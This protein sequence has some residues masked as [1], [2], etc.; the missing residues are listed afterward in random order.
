MK[1][2]MLVYPLGSIQNN[3]KCTQVSFART[4][5]IG[6]L[7][8]GDIVITHKQFQLHLDPSLQLSLRLKSLAKLG[9][10]KLELFISLGF[11]ITL[12]QTF[13]RILCLCA[14]PQR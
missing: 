14:I 7:Q 5:S 2:R 1:D 11:S 13:F 9:V 4:M 8:F 10:C 12:Y 3:S 6:G